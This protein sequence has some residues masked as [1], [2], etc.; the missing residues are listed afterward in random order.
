MFECIYMD[1]LLMFFFIHRTT[2][3]VKALINE[4]KNTDITQSYV[5]SFGKFL[6]ISCD[7]GLWKSK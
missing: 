6:R 1:F 7:V 4:L 2:E 5:V 3:E